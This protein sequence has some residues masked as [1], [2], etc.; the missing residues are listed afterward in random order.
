MIR[1]IQHRLLETA[2]LIFLLSLLIFGL[3]AAVPGDYLSEME[4]NPAIPASQVERMRAEFGLDQPFHLQ[5]FKWLSQVGRGN[6]GYSFAQRRPATS[7]IAERAVNTL[8]LA[9]F[10]LLFSVG[11]ALPLA[12]VSSLYFNRWPDHLS[13][14]ISLG[15]MSLPTLLTSLLFLYLAFLTGWFPIGGA[16]T[17]RHV[18][19]PALT[20]ALPLF[21]FLTRTLRLE[22]VDA[23]S[24][25]FITALRSKG[26]PGRQV[27]WY[28]FRQALNPVIS[29]SGL[30]LGGLLSGSVVVERVFGWPGLGELTVA[31]ILARD[32][33]VALNCVLVASGLVILANFAA[34]IV[35]ACNDPRVRA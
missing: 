13:R 27:F 34:D 3:F 8:L 15:G 10:A 22:L 23:L 1:L 35:L 6:L 11:L 32:L 7:L 18:I 21:S 20:L 19:L 26:L 24:Q 17:L 4:L 30:I 2:V 9:G 5:Y 16:G 31:S 29:L 12:V 33:Y 14:L 25:P 28:A